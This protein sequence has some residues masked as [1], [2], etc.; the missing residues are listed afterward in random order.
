M[1]VVVVVVLVEVADEC[2]L[3]VWICQSLTMAATG[4]Y[5]RRGVAGRT[6]MGGS[7]PC[8]LLAK[9]NVYSER[10]SGWVKLQMGVLGFE[11]VVGG[12]GCSDDNG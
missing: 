6:S 12:V 5:R 10:P 9:N 4:I 8:L 1:V 7:G 11:V 2:D 3:K